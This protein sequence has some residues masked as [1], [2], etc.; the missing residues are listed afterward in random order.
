M[1]SNAFFP[2]SLLLLFFFFF[3]FFIFLYAPVYGSSSSCPVSVCNSSSFMVRFPFWQQDQPPPNCSHPGFKLSCSD[4]G[5]TV[6]ILPRAGEFLVRNINF[7]AQSI[8]VY[9]PEGCLP[10]QLLRFSISGSP[11]FVDSYVNCTFLRCRPEEITGS[12]SISAATVDCLGNSSRPVIATSSEALANSMAEKCEK[13]ATSSVPVSMVKEDGNPLKLSGDLQLKWDVPDCR[14]RE[15]EGGICAFDSNFSQQIGCF[16][17]PPADLGPK[18]QFLAILSG[19]NP[20][21]L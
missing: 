19:E 1:G 7:T 18:S 5:S 15:E 9:D 13:I 2:I 20:A 8:R 6:L 21:V 14:R 4:Q 10:R 12:P 16:H 3:I 17:S 11:F